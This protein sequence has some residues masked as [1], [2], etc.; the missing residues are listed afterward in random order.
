MKRS[1][2]RYERGAAASR[3]REAIHG[4]VMKDESNVENMNGSCIVL[5]TARKKMMD[6]EKKKGG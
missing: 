5:L 4:G 2:E 3:Q 1:N 6:F